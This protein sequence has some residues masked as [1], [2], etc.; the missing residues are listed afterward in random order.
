MMLIVGCVFTFIP[1]QVFASWI[2]HTV[3]S[4][5]GTT[6]SSPGSYTVS[7][8][9]FADNMYVAP[10]GNITYNYYYYDPEA[11]DYID[12]TKD[13]IVTG[14]SSSTLDT[15]G[16]T[17]GSHA[18]N[19]VTNT[20]SPITHK[21]AAYCACSAGF[22]GSA[23]SQ[24]STSTVA[25]FIF[26]NYSADSYTFGD[27]S[28]KDNGGKPLFSLTAPQYEYDLKNTSG[29]SHT[30][31]EESSV[32]ITIDDAKG[33]DLVVNF[34]S[35]VVISVGSITATASGT[36][37]NTKHSLLGSG[38]TKSHYIYQGTASISSSATYTA[39]VREEVADVSAKRVSEEITSGTT[40]I[41]YN[42]ISPL[43]TLSPPSL[44]ELKA[45]LPT[46]PVA[47]E[48]ETTE[49][50]EIRKEAYKSVLYPIGYYLADTYAEAKTKKENK[51][52]LSFPL[53]NISGNITIWVDW[54]TNNPNNELS[55]K[56]DINQE[57]TNL[58]AGS[59]ISL[60]GV[61][62]NYDSTGGTPVKVITN[63]ISYLPNNSFGLTAPEIKGTLNLAFKFTDYVKDSS[64]ATY[65]A[66][67][68]YMARKEE[69]NAS[70]DYNVTETNGTTDVTVGLSNN[71]RD[72]T[73]VLQ[74][75]VKV[76]GALYVGGYTGVYKS[77]AS[78]QSHG[79]IIGNYVA[80]DLNGHTLRVS[81]TL[82]SFGY[83]YDSVG[84]GKIIVE[85]SGTFCTPVAIYGM[86]SLQHT[87]RSYD[88][89]YS[90]FEDYNL[91]YVNAD[92]E[93]Q[94][95]GT[96]SATMYGFTILYPS[97]D[98][99]ILGQTIPVPLYNYY[100]KMFGDEADA[101]FKMSQKDGSKE[102]KAIITSTEIPS[103][104]V[105]AVTDAG[106]NIKNTFLLENQTI[107]LNSP[108]IAFNVPIMGDISIDFR[109]AIF[110]I[111]PLIDVTVKSSDLTIAQKIALMPGSTLTVDEN[112]TLKLVQ[113]ETVTFKGIDPGLVAQLSW[114]ATKTLAGGI[115]VPTYNRQSTQTTIA[116]NYAKQ[117]L[118]NG[119]YQSSYFWKSFGSAALNIY[120]T[121]EFA[122]GNSEPY[123]LSGNVNINKFKVGSNVYD[124]DQKNLNST[125]LSGVKLRTYGTFI[126]IAQCLTGGRE[127]GH[128]TRISQY[129]VAPVIS[130]GKAYIYD[131]DTYSSAMVGRFDPMTGVFTNSTD[132]KTYVLH[133]SVTLPGSG[134]GGLLNFNTTVAE[135]TVTD[136]EIAT[137]GSTNYVY[138]GGVYV[139]ITS[140]TVDSPGID[141]K[142]FI[143]AG[144]AKTLAWNATYQRW[145]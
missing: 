44:A 27:F 17:L 107:V 136:K 6:P 57:I 46:N 2:I 47:I 101:L 97:S 10:E 126:A 94:T 89:G 80:L 29:N 99:T 26:G 96:D 143:S 40:P 121:V 22:L 141:G 75:D 104:N 13:A 83:I 20:L 90:P 111:S 49:E 65:Y 67:T 139:P 130:N 93:L 9:Y 82:H 18:V 28:E 3:P 77:P 115:Y 8:R 15:S 125:N 42:R 132:N 98:Q 61:A 144:A 131:G 71:V 112:S 12:T 95:V 70:R 30:F 86:N 81:G 120:G 43:D 117:G 102:S 78:N 54:A 7:F 138:Y 34:H 122:T 124:W 88:G 50:Y 118:S 103:L 64:G 33:L 4:G 135:A 25:S 85:P 110:P 66:L 41:T 58:A 37:N 87:M 21:T 113:G 137:V 52:T 32:I 69:A 119:S 53:T 16:I 91:P 68:D 84:T 114:D 5:S 79:Y 56:T 108:T 45:A 48:G 35:T 60:G 92:V 36:C 133:V 140:G 55:G 14:S 11:S 123:V 63:D 19:L 100:M 109:R 31:T 51:Q 24:S 1:T 134:Q 129:Y 142:M 62:M 59:S 39:Y 116:Y 76:S 145:A 74:N 128:S 105:A 127:D 106:L 72:Y 38:C 73:V 23:C